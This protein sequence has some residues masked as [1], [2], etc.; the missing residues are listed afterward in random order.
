MEE[1]CTGR[2]LC[3]KVHNIKMAFIEM[4]CVAVG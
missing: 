3:T 4:G 2:N 1:V